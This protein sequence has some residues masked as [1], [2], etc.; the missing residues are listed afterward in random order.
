[1]ATEFQKKEKIEIIKDVAAGRLD[2]NV[3]KLLLEHFHTNRL[4]ILV[5]D[6]QT[7]ELVPESQLKKDLLDKLPEKYKKSICVVEI[8]EQDVQ[9]GMAT[10]F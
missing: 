9:V 8:D 6:D 7:R 2:P 3:A 1:M 4:V 5:H 10:E